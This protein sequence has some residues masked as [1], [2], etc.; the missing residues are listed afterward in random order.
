M[1]YGILLMILGLLMS[2]C[3]R[4]ATP[5][6]AVQTAVQSKDRAATLQKESQ[7]RVSEADAIVGGK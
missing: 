4:E 7:Q 6:A 2:G 3:E 1:K 5:E